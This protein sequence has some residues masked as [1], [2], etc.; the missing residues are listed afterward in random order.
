MLQDL[1][2]TYELAFTM[3]KEAL[4]SLVRQ[5]LPV[6]PAKDNFPA[7]INLSVVATETTL[8]ITGTDLS[9]V[10]TVLTKDVE[11]DTPGKALLPARKL[12]RILSEAERDQKI[13]ICVYEGKSWIVAESQGEAAQ[14]ELPLHKFSTY[15][16]IDT[17]TTLHTIDRL[18]FVKALGAV[19]IAASKDPSMPSRTVIAATGNTLTACDGNRLQRM[20]LPDF[21]PFDFNI[22]ISKTE[23][24]LNTLNASSLNV[25]AIGENDKYLFFSSDGKALLMVAKTSI[26]FPNVDRV[27]L[28]PA[29]ENTEELIVARKDLISAVKKVRVASDSDR[30]TVTL[31]LSPGVIDLS[32][33]DKIGNRA[34]T[35][36]RVTWGGPNMRLIFNHVYLLDLLRTHKSER[37]SLLLGEDTKLKKSPLL[38]KSDGLTSILQQVATE[39]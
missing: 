33:G 28:R 21:L 1:L 11:V 19:K 25:M 4:A 27:I 5:V 14:W 24:L 7:L 23:L 16:K 22:P 37:C 15:P 2:T 36:L 38:V 30:G 32:A 13:A 6:V 34:N 9:S 26:K 12:L 31:D 3:D 10:V 18:S 35:S 20:E 39:L 17:K 8:R 29:M